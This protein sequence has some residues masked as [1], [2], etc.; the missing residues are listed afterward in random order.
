[1]KTQPQIYTDKFMSKNPTVLATK[2]NIEGQTCTYYEHPTQGE[3]ACVYVMIDGV[4]AD[5]D[6]YDVDQPEDYEP[7]LK[8]GVIACKFEYDAI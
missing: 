1:M 5:T 6:F 8:D 3:D 2:V 4:L 7:I